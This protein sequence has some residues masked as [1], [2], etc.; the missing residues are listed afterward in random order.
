MY[1]DW[2]SKEIVCFMDVLDMLIVVVV[3]VWIVVK[4]NVVK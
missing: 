4:L 1:F 3:V 2:L